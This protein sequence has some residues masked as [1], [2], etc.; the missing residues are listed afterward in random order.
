MKLGYLTVA[1]G[2]M[3]LEKKA[4]WANENGFEALEIACWPKRNDRDYSSS[5]IDV[6]TLDETGAARIKK[7]MRDNGLTISSLAYY[8]NNLDR[9]PEKRAFINGHVKKVIDAAVML[10]ADLVGTFTGRNIE[11]SIKDN[12]PEFQSVFTELA[13]YAERRNIR[14]M[15]ENCDMRGWQRAGEPGTISYSP[16][17]WEEMFRRVPA[18]NFGLNYDPSHLVLMLMDYLSPIEEFRDRIFHVHAKDAVIRKGSLDR[19]GI[20]DRQLGKEGTADYRDFKMPGLGEIDW[21]RVIKSLRSIGYD[22]VLSIEHEDREYAGSE[23]KVKE[24]LLAARDNL[25]RYI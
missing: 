12:F 25:K 1:L 7:L 24:G 15:I 6:K 22:N 10:G 11:K 2:N 13:E 8:D 5:D 20:F 4:A 17:L 23:E 18:P 3:P 19:Y 21:D 14:L 16:E 9:D